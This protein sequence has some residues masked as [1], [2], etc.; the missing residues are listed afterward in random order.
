[1]SGLFAEHYPD[2]AG[3]KARETS[4]EAAEAVTPKAKTLRQRVLET[5]AQRPASPEQIAKALGEPV[6]N[7]RP[8]LSEL[9]KL[10]LVEDSGMRA[11]AMG[12]RK[13]IVWRTTARAGD[14]AASP[15]ERAKSGVGSDD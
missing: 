10:N 2:A 13:A 4:R 6:M 8:R 12:G 11:I 9:A 5:V 3:W 15:S 7:I 1:M 14:Q